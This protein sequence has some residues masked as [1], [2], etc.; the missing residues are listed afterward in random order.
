MKRNKLIKSINTTPVE[1]SI[2][3]DKR[4]PLA[5]FIRNHT[6]VPIEICKRISYLFSL[7]RYS[8]TC[9]PVRSRYPDSTILCL[10]DGTDR[11]IDQSV[12]GMKRV[13]LSGSYVAKQQP[14][15]QTNPNLLLSVYKDGSTHMKTG[16]KGIF[17][18]GTI[19]NKPTFPCNAC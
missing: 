13:L 6:I 1:S 14:I 16:V 11:V 5:E 4:G 12:H 19:I 3:C 10:N 7:S 8:D 17:F 2:F 9:Y 15:F 18:L